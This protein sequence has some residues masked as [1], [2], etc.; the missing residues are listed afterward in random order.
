MDTLFLEI[1]NNIDSF[2]GIKY[3][4]L[5]VAVFLEGPVVTVVAATLASEGILKPGMVIVSAALGNFTADISWYALGYA[6]RYARVLDHIPWL[7][8]QKILIR[9]AQKKMHSH[10][11]RILIASKL[12]LGFGA[13]PTFIAAGLLH[14]PWYRLVP[15]IILCEIFCT[16]AL[17][18]FGYLASEYLGSFENL[19]DVLL[20]FSTIFLLGFLLSC[21][22]KK[23]I[24]HRWNNPRG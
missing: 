12:C 7:R 22:A 23:K 14:L 10:G 21:T 5:F 3:L 16:G 18:A 1:S 20:L 8:H 2:Y 4:L 11:I 6:G 13:I 15:A 17:V 24:H 9:H 19:F